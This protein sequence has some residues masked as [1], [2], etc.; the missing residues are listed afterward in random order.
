MKVAVSGSSGFIGAEVCR[1]L[2]E[3]SHEPVPISDLRR[4]IDNTSCSRRLLQRRLAR[5]DAVIH[6]AARAHISSGRGANALME[7]RRANV[8]T[9][10][11]MIQAAIQAGVARFVFVSSIGVLGNNS[12]AARFTEDSPPAPI[13]P[14][15]ISKLEAEAAVANL[16]AREKMAFTIVRPPL[17]Y[18]PRVRG[19]FLRLLHLVRAGWPLPFGGAAGL[20][21]FIGVTNLASLLFL[22]ASSTAAAGQIFLAS[23][24]ED[25]SLPDL[26]RLLGHSMQRPSRLFSAPASLLRAAAT[27]LGRGVEV[28]KLLANLRVDA[29]KSRVTLGW[30]PV[31]DLNTGLAEM[32]HWYANEAN[33]HAG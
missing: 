12:G 31:K 32:A 26:L 33:S 19:N 9:T 20:R 1:F 8:S 27:I 29:T 24:G 25:I 6:L 11:A 30:R 5:A 14:Y 23:D 13:E 21:S 3:R 22:C 18:G 16:C 17:V 28:D 4:L 7:F 2:T 10:I 15:A